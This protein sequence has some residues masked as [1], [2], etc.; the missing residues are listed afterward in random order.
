MPGRVCCCA[1][2]GDFGLLSRFSVDL[3]FCLLVIITPI[4]ALDLQKKR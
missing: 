3:A 2:I 4:E 1:G